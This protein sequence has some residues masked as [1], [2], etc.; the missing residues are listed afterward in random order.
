[1]SLGTVAVGEVGIATLHVM[2][3]FEKGL[4]P[5]SACAGLSAVGDNKPWV[6]LEYKK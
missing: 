1:M 5:S 4:F 2:C 6:L 3:P